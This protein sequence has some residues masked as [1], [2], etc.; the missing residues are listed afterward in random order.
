MHKH[1]ENPEVIGYGRLPA[2]SSL[3]RNGQSFSLAGMWYFKRLDKPPEDTDW[4]QE[5]CSDWQVTQVPGLWTMDPQVPEDQPVYTNVLM[6]FRGEPPAIPE[7]PA[8]L[9]RRTIELDETAENGRWILQLNG[10]ESACY[11]FCNGHEVGFTKDSRLPSSFDLSEH[12]RPGRN[13]IAIMVLRYCDSSYIEDQDQW[14]HAGIHRDV[15][16]YRTPEVHIRDVFARPD[17]N[18]NTGRGSL[19][20]TIRLGDQNR[21]SLNHQVNVTVLNSKG[22]SLYGKPL[23]GRVEK[24]SFHAVVGKG[25]VINLEAPTRKVLPWNAEQPNLYTVQVE[26]EDDSG[27]IIETV[28]LRIGFRS[29]RIEDRQ[30]LVNG[31]PVLIRGVNRH[32]HSD[33]TGKVLSEAD[34]RRDLV[35]MKQHNIN[36]VRTSHYP[37][38][39]CFYDLCDELGLYVVDE[40]NVEAHH[41]YAQLGNDPWWSGQFL[42]RGVRMVERDKN[43]ACIIM[44]SVGNETGFGPN[45]M[46]MIGWIREYDPSRPIHNEPAICEQNVRDMWNENTHG[47]DVVCPMY[48]AVSD[49][50]RH[51][52]ESEDTRPLIM[53]EF[54]HAMGNSCGNLQ[55]YWDAIETWHGLQGG[56]IWEWKDHGIRASANGI[57]YWAYGGDFGEWRHDLN[58]VCD[59]L[60]WPDGTPH[61]SLIEY[62]SVIQPVTVSRV[63]KK[64]FRFR[65]LN[66]HDFIDLSRYRGIWRLLKNGIEVHQSSLPTFRTPAQYYEDFEINP[67]DLDLKSEFSVVFEFQ[68]GADCSWADNGHCI[69]RSQI[70]L[71]PPVKIQTL[72]PVSQT[73][74][75]QNR[76]GI[77][78]KTESQ[79]LKFDRD[80]L[81]SWQLGQCELLDGPLQINLWRAPTDNDGI[82]GQPNQDSK[83][84]AAWLQLGLDRIS[85]QHHLKVSESTQGTLISQDSIG[86]CDGGKITVKTEYKIAET[87]ISVRHKFQIPKVFKDLPRIGVRWQFKGQMEKMR[88]LGNGPHETYQ[89]RRTSAIR[90]VHESTV[91][92]QYVP[93]VLPQE[94]GNLTDVSWLQLRDNQLSVTMR[95]SNPLQA[96]ASHYPHEVLTPAF[97][98]YE[99]SPHPSS[100]LSLDVRQRGLGGA[101]CGPDTLPEYRV[102]PGQYEL[103]YQIEPEK[104]T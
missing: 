95:S 39:S 75:S 88:W 94:H 68:L 104:L 69:A 7:N 4:I 47:T 60:C 41:H 14:W 82:K 55:E 1:W 27:S 76:N 50:I 8:G 5:D 64:G 35:T 18:E 19:A 29:I 51:A 92:E 20:L 61:T 44:W 73:S 28:S 93:Y 33:I 56:F 42:A 78:I 46:S 17:Y 13:D 6:P 87:G 66:K 40:A 53:C 97:H 83:P 103:S 100:W 22:R 9:Y 24:S 67:G 3:A 37:N 91:T 52:R 48:P 2:H 81:T 99:L 63:G 54:A 49:I 96:S 16:L 102:G 98:T 11:L 101:S 36:A 77:V 30:L 25:A 31:V 89:D 57:D 74:V 12:L 32:D 84:W 23:T 90:A 62:K 45:H 86:V 34:M 65:I 70:P 10:V 26:L 85:W 79:T 59:G 71:S 72:E 58:F 43:H 21:S 38:E 15:V 80:G